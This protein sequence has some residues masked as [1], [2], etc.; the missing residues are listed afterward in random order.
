ML[1]RLG[2]TAVYAV[3]TL[4]TAELFPTEIRNSALGISSTMAHVGSITAPYIVD[5]LVSQETL[6]TVK[7]V[8]F[9]FFFI[10]GCLGM[11]CAYHNLW[12]YNFKC[13]SIDTATT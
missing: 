7:I 10:P 9:F 4:H 1:G 8:T 2:I 5:I 12:Y 13:G 11:V 3:M 6:A